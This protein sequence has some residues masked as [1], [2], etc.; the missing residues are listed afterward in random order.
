MSKLM[1]RE[2]SL[3]AVNTQITAD[4]RAED[5]KIQTS[6]KGSEYLRCKLTDRSGSVEGVMWD[7]NPGMAVQDK[8]VYSFT[9]EVG[10]YNGKSQLKIKY[11]APR[12]STT[13]DDF[14]KVSEY[15]IDWMWGKIVNLIGTM[16]NEWI[17]MTAEELMLNLGLSDAFKRAPAASGMHHAFVGGLLE[18]TSQM[19]EIGDTLLKLP[20]FERVLNRDLCLF[21]LMFHDFGKIF[22]Y[23]H[24]NGFRR[25]LQGR[26]VP[27][28][29]M[30]AAM[31]YHYAACVQIPEIIRDHMMHV[32][33]AHHGKV[34]WGSPISMNIPEAAFVHYIDHMHGD[35]FGWL[36]KIHNEAQ[37]GDIV[38][39]NYMGKNEL[40]V[41]RFSDILKKCEAARNTPSSVES[42]PAAQQATPT[43][44]GFLLPE[45]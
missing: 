42:A 12:Q 14:E 38:V 7:Y 15:P 19:L 40:V 18:H 2:L 17:R 9:G 36:Q 43:E 31:V 29:P 44:E 39:K 6:K 26:L 28:I 8:A 3:A 20:F 33:L 37:P 13:D 35:V 32:V 27:H 4:F 34:E 11:I 23:E 21:G 1:A 41:E 24:G 22:E 25:T 5:V 16:Q 10:E 30:V 45:I